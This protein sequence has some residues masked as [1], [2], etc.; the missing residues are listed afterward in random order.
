M[1]LIIKPKMG[2]KLVTFSVTIEPVA[3]CYSTAVNKL[4]Y[5]D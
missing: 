4:I 1:N 5:T 3:I 2:C